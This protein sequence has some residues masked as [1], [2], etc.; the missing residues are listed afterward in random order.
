MSA[1]LRLK[2]LLLLLLTAV[3]PLASATQFS[4]GELAVIFYSVN[5]T[6]IEPNTYIFNLGRADLFRE[7]TLRGV[8]VTQINPAIT[9]DNIGAD[10]ATAF[11]SDWAEQGTV[12]WAVVGTV[13]N[14]SPVINGDP[15]RTIYISRPRNS[16][17]SGASG[18]ATTINQISTIGIGGISNDVS[19]LYTG[20]NSAISPPPGSG[21]TSI[22]AT[23]IRGTISPSSNPVNPS[24]FLP[25]S[26]ST[27]FSHSI[28]PRQTFTGVP[29]AGGTGVSGALDIYRVLRF[30]DGADLTSGQSSGNAVVQEGQFIGTLTL[31][32]SGNL[33]IGAEG[34]APVQNFGTWATA[35]N[36]TG[37]LS[38]DSDGDGILNIVE[39]AL[40]LNLQ[41][42]DASIGTF[43]GGV[44][45]FNKR[46]AAVTNGDVAY[47]IETSDDLGVTMPWTAVAATSNT[48][49]QI[50]YALPTGKTKT[51][52]RLRVTSPAN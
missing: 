17:T 7:N 8:S 47:V 43:S 52:A 4:S 28:D 19:V 18:P 33:K 6:V 14:G 9:S 21:Y 27:F 3:S 26:T 10:L 40:D 11:G 24:I 37:G 42:P 44:I 48:T 5:G 29:V 45:S 25:P 51:F 39:Y 20:T 38:G 32:A 35:N 34:G 12:R 16:L 31:D 15:N 30:T 36:I 41:G 13:P 50:T 22:P 23:N 1:R 2:N 49:S 46:P